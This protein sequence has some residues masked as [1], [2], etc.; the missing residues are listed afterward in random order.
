[1]RKSPSIRPYRGTF[2]KSYDPNPE[3]LLYE[4]EI[5]NP[6]KIPAPLA[7][8]AQELKPGLVRLSDVLGVMPQKGWIYVCKGVN[9]ENRISPAIRVLNVKNLSVENVNIHHAGGMGII[10]EKSTNIHLNSFN[11][12]RT[13]GSKR[14]L[15][16]T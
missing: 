4:P 6:S 1:V 2:N 5:Y 3:P 11:V 12:K 16:T 10:V 8:K 15:S 9:S 14:M 13:E 7:V